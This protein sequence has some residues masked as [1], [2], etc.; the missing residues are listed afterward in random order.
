MTC[1]PHSPSF[2]SVAVAR[3][4]HGLLPHHRLICLAVSAL[5]LS[6]LRRFYDAAAAAAKIDSLDAPLDSPRFRFQSSVTVDRLYALYDL[7]QSEIWEEITT[8]STDLWRR[9]EAFVIAVLCGDRFVHREFEAALALVRLQDPSNPSLLSRL[10][11][12]QLQI[13]DLT[14]AKA[15]FSMLESLHHQSR[16]SGHWNWKACG[17]EQGTGVHRCPG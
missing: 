12:V 17:E 11:Y 1:H 8:A 3:R 13:G 9:R 15:P 6:K 7:V 16:G 5:A 2:A 4:S 10:G 14:G